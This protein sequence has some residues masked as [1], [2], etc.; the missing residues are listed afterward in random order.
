M[1]NNWIYFFVLIAL[2]PVILLRDYTPGNELRYLSIADEAMRNGR[3]FA[4]TNHGIP[5]AD[6]PPLYFWIIGMGK[7]LFGKHC[8]AFLSLFS[9]IPAFIIVGI[10]DRWTSG[11]I[12]KRYRLTW[13]LLMLSCGLF[14]GM[15]VVL[16]MDMLMCMFITLSLYT[17]Y[18]MKK[19]E[20]N[21]AVHTFLFPIFLFLAVFSKGPI[22]ILIPL[23]S[24]V[25]F[26]WLT[27]RIRTIGR[28]WGW[29]T[30]G[31][32]LV[33]FAVWFVAV[34]AEGGWEYLHNLLFHQTL[35]RAVNSFHHEAPFYYYFLSIGY[36]LLPW[37]LLLIGILVT[38]ICKKW[39]RTDLQKFFLTIVGVTFLLLSA[40]SSK[41][42]VYMLPAFP[43]IAYLAL[44]YFHHLA[45]NRW[46]ALSIAVPAII[47]CLSL[48]A[49]LGIAQR[50]D[51]HFL[52][53]VLFRVAA[54]TLT[55]T[56]LLTLY[57]LYRRKDL[58]YA[59]RTLAYGLFG[60]IF[61]GGWALPRINSQLGYG[62]LC[63]QATTIAATYHLSNYYV[64]KLYR[65]E[66]IDVYLQKEVQTLSPEEPIQANLH[67]AVLMLPTGEVDGLPPCL[68]VRPIYKVG[69]YAIIPIP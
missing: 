32:L 51:T 10:M 2:L 35:D 40:I 25:T 20:G 16:R 28:Y 46:L 49:L 56:G 27:G 48:P 39:I 62:D 65:P 54:G 69:N 1:K 57:L 36:S 31:I 17:F 64:W 3:W 14:A 5:Y 12:E 63:K 53:Q 18:Q 30:W 4:F 13:Q 23:I 44:M 29:K 59:I 11:E 24:T 34:Y 7:Y 41:I 50:E 37:S 9:L 19:R 66:N 43:F 8:M 61:I 26:L 58:N 60:S 45:W 33:C 22:G 15:T 42:A 55:L 47:F 67:N 68:S 21:Q 52:G 38:A 6:K